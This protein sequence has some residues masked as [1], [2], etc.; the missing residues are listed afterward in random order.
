MV[1]AVL[2]GLD[3]LFALLEQIAFRPE[4]LLL[5]IARVAFLF[6]DVLPARG[7]HIVREQYGLRVVGVLQLADG[8]PAVVDLLLPL[9]THTVQFLLGGLVIGHFAQYVLG[10]HESDALRMYPDRRKKPAQ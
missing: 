10:V 6:L 2:D 9:A 4:A 3:Q 8:L 5:Q 1:N 7:L